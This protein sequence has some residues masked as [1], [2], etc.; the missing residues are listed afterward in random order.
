MAQAVRRVGVFIRET[1]GIVVECWWYIV[2]RERQGRPA[3]CPASEYASTGALYDQRPG[4]HRRNRDG[5]RVALRDECNNITFR[6]RI[7]EPRQMVKI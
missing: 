7:T 6:I 3:G 2:V 5:K 4:A 1:T